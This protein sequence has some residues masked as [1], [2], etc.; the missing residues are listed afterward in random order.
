MKEN[1]AITH[2]SVVVLQNGGNIHYRANNLSRS[3]KNDF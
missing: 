1:N 3:A 2:T